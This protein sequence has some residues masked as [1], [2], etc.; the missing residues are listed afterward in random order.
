[1]GA[2]VLDR[3][4]RLDA[5]VEVARHQIGAAE[6][7]ARNVP[8]FEDED[9]A[10]LEKAP[11]HADDADV[12]AESFDARAQG[13]DAACEDLDL[14]AFHRRL[15][16]LVD[17]RL[18]GQVVDLDPD[19]RLVAGCGRGR[20][21]PDLLDQPF[22]QIEGRDQELAEPRRPAEAGQEVEQVGNV[23]GDVGIGREQAE[24]LI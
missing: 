13:A 20:G 17:D 1:M 12:V 9:A 16:E 22:A 18:V 3:H 23:G 14:D 10:V 2:R 6:V 5:V 15:V 19:A 7:V 24:V 8:R 4:D 11:E 21:R